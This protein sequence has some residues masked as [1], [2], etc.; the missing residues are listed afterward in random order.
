MKAGAV[1]T[2]TY[3]DGVT[4]NFCIHQVPPE[5]VA[6]VKELGS[7]ALDTVIKIVTFRT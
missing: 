3:A 2:D 4:V 7:A 6:R 1:Y 5:Q